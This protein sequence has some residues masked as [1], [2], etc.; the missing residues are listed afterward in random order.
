M[1][2]RI[3]PKRTSRKDVTIVNFTEKEQCGIVQG[4]N[5]SMAIS[6]GMG[7]RKEIT[8]RKLRVAFRKTIS[9]AKSNNL[10]RIAI[11]LQSLAFPHLNMNDVQRGKMIVENCILADYEFTKYKRP[12]GTHKGNVKEVVLVGTPSREL[13]QGISTGKTIANTVNACRDL[14]NTRA[15]DLTPVGLARAAHDAAQ[16]LPVKVTVLG[17]KEMKHQAMNGILQVAKGS[18]EEPRLIIMEYRNGSEKKPIVLVGKG[19]TY[20]SGGLNIKTGDAFQD[21]MHL[22]MAGGAAVI[23]TIA[24]AARL[25]IKKNVIGLIPAVENMPSGTSL[26]P[27][28]II[29]TMAGI[30]VEVTNTD[31][32]GRVILA[33][34]LT[35]AQH[36][37]PTLVVDIATLTSAAIT[38][39]G[40]K[41]SVLFTRDAALQA[42]VQQL[43]EESG[44]YV[45]PLPLWEEYEQDIKSAHA[46]LTAGRTKYGGA[47]AAAAFLSHFTHKLPWIHID[48]APRMTAADGEYLAKGATGE[49]VRLLIKLLEHYE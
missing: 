32:E 15:V 36:Y 39:L 49:P 24:L 34:A 38:A 22:D 31:A 48:I 21:M 6:I 5:G 43:G 25:K 23:H 18:A 4:K 41:A 9:L 29:K 27:G 45:W 40:Q 47:C 46:D 44:D 11:P 16:G 2:I 30:T 20:D 13:R 37:Q 7:K 19:V 14:A 17:E 42:L 10:T 33:D 26:K 3:V 12:Q 35:Y 1:T 28:D 8:L